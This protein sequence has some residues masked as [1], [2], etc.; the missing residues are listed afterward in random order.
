MRKGFDRVPPGY[1][2]PAEPDLDADWMHLAEKLTMDRPK[3]RAKKLRY[4]PAI[5]LDFLQKI[6]VIGDA[7]PLILIALTEMRMRRTSEIALGPPIWATV[8]KPGRRTRSRMLQQLSS[9][10]ASLCEVRPRPGRPHLLVAGP[11]WPKPLGS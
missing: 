7:V 4:V 3:Q 5:P 8:G 11:D 1:Q 9:L 10:P 6:L 2:K